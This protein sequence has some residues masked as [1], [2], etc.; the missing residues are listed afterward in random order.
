MNK[1]AFTLIE[2]L[3]VVLI[4]GILTAVVLPQYRR[5]IQKAEASEAVAML[6]VIADSSDRLANE[7]GYR[8]FK[9]MVAD[10]TDGAKAVFSRLDMFAKDTIKCSF[11]AATDRI[12]TCDHF[13]YDL[14]GE[15]SG[16]GSYVSAE[17]LNSPYAG[18][19]IRFYPQ[20]DSSLPQLR[21]TGSGA[22]GGADACDL[23]N[24]DWEEH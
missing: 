10:E 21:C 23:Y 11:D 8:T 12:M 13:K 5:A 1:R 24:I 16:D 18:T 15:N 2:M 14:L 4:I 20:T 6:R 9:N 22:D 7:F 17:K 3:T 19:I